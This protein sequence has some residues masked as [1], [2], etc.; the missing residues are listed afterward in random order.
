MKEF[1]IVE[2][3]GDNNLFT[4][5]DGQSFESQIRP[6]INLQTGQVE[7]FVEISSD[8]ERATAKSSLSMDQCMQLGIEDSDDYRRAVRGNS[9]ESSTVS[10]G[11]NRK[12]AQKWGNVF[13][14]DN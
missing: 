14:S 1:K 13:A 6:K 12:Y 2:V 3:E 9:G 5:I 7:E 11:S 8:G 4:G 10:V